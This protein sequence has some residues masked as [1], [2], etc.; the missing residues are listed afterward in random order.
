MHC[1]ASFSG[2]EAGK[3]FLRDTLQPQAST[4]LWSQ[5]PHSFQNCRLYGV[6]VEMDECL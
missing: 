4:R 3:H 1:G 5:G 2:D 6:G